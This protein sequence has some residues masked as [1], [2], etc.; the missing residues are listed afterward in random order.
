[1]VSSL[2]E[3]LRSVLR[4]RLAAA[5]AVAVAAAAAAVAAAAAAA[6]AA[7][8]NGFSSYVLRCSVS[9]NALSG[10]SFDV[11]NLHVTQSHTNIIVSHMGEASGRIRTLVHIPRLYHLC[12]RIH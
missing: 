3:L 4:A 7:A 12:R 9:C 1:M 10:H 2:L 8:V 5:A 6:A 11:D